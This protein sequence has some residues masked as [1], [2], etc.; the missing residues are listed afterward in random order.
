[1]MTPPFSISARPTLTRNDSFALM[2][3]TSSVR[4]PTTSTLDK[5]R[6]IGRA[7][8]RFDFLNGFREKTD[9]PLDVFPL[10]ARHGKPHVGAVGPARI[11]ILSRR[12]ADS[13]VRRGLGHSA[14]RDALREMQPEERIR[15]L[16]SPP[17]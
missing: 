3:T 11:E 16:P 5:R 6:G 8:P 9:P 7:R 12:D 14:P 2:A 17:G 1:M 15:G 4:S 10:D 13:P